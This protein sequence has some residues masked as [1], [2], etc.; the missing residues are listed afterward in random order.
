MDYLPYYYSK[1][2][3]KGEK[4]GHENKNI[5]IDTFTIYYVIWKFNDWSSNKII[6][7]VLGIMILIS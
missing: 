7:Y 2:V 6:T 5:V 1:T 3:Q 4:K